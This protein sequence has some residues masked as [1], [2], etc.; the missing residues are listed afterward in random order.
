MILVEI[1]GLQKTTLI[2]FPGKIACIVFLPNCNFNCGF[3]FNR[4]LVKAPEELETVSEKGFFD[5]L[6]KRKKWLDGVVI[7]GGEP[8]LQSDLQDF[9]RKIRA[10]GFLVKLDTN[11]SNPSVLEK[12]LKEKLVD[13]VAMDIKSSLQ[14]YEKAT[15]CKVDLNRISKSAELIM[16]AAPDYEFR[17]TVLPKFFSKE[18][19]LAV[20]E[21]LKGAK[22]FVLQQFREQADLIDARFKKENKYSEAELKELAALLEK[23]FEK[24]EVRA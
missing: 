10:L 23:F 13:F 22:K 21:W 5:F 16:K 12:L 4:Q 7:T 6:E 15:N 11:G 8:T 1:K 24:V 14:N 17:C 18:D 20:G 19:A 9:I 2:D 3:C